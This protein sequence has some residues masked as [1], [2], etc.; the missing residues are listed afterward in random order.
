MKIL[1]TA[2]PT[3]EYIDDVR[4]IS[5][6]SSGL[7]GYE[8]A[9]VCAR[10]GHEVR[11][12]SGP[13]VLPAP[14]VAELTRIES[15]EEMREAV[16]R[17]F[18]WA[19]CVFM[20]A[21]PVDVRPAKR[22]SGKIK[23]LKEELSLKMA[24]TPDILAELGARKGKKVLVGFALE[25]QDAEKHALEKLRAKNLDYIAVNSPAS[26]G[27]RAT[28]VTIISRAGERIVLEARSKHDIAETLV[29]VACGSGETERGAKGDKVT[30]QFTRKKGC[31]D[32]PA[33]QYMSAHAS[34]MDVCAAVESDQTLAPG[35]IALIPTGLFIAC[36]PGYEVQ[37]RPRSGLALKHGIMVVN[38]P[39]TIDSD[40]RGEV[41]VILGN[42]GKAPFVVQ[43]G[44]RIAQL[45]VQP[46]VRAEMVEVQELEDTKRSAGGFGSTGTR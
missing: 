24:P 40:Y 46:V 30:I 26:F 14:P 13:S 8:I 45:V 23:K 21:A 39:G 38:S 3:R 32:V 41:C 36:P 33:P 25:V 34:G 44:I 22:V 4:F 2:G 16:L 12:V 5:N 42:M 27:A 18:E 10:A 43:R 35:Q 37:V 19:D 15:T 6:P 1:V 7:M 9:E 31:E 17:S 29:R 28:S 20:A 11:L